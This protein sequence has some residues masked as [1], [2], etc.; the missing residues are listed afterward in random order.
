M[1]R[2]IT[3]TVYTLDEL[4]AA[5]RDPESSVTERSVQRAIDWLREGAADHDWWDHLIKQDDGLWVPALEQIGFTDP[6]ISFTGFWSQGDGASFTAGIDVPRLAAFLADPPEPGDAIEPMPDGGEDFRPWIVKH[7]GGVSSDRRF[8]HIARFGSLVH[9]HVERIDRMYAHEYTCRARVEPDW[10]FTGADF[11][12][13][14]RLVAGF[15]EA[16]EQLR[17]DMSRA[18]FRS[19]EEEHD[20][21][22]GDEAQ[23]E[24]AEA[25]EYTFDED[26]RRF[27]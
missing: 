21:L 13:A 5:A 25:N 26:G 9:G 1:T 16:V 27:G 23:A 15:E 8:R 3:T 7:C 10:S 12:A 4:K 6:D 14:E 2:E 19:L 22:T 24:M 11:P 17:I 20:Y 18:I